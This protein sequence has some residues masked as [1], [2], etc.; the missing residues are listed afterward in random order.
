MEMEYSGL[1][2]RWDLVNRA[3]GG[4]FR[5]NEVTFLAGPSGSG[6]SF[7][8]NML[9]EDFA[10]ELNVK[11]PS[12]FKILAFSF[13]MSAE[14]EIIRSYSSQLKTSYSYLLSSYRKISREYYALIEETSRKVD[15]DVIHY[16]ESPGDRNQIANTVDD[17]HKK[18]PRHKL[19]ITIDHTLLMDYLDETSE[20]HL[21]ANMAKL[22]MYL[23]KKYRAMVIMLGQLNDKIENPD[24]IKNP[25]LHFPRKTD[26]HGSKQVFMASDTVAIIHRPELLHIDRYGMAEYNGNYG[27]PTKNLIAWHF[28]KSRLHGNE[29]IVLMKQDFEHGT[30][31]YP[32]E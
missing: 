32:Y 7:I 10:G 24:R 5:F 6:K 19:I 17:F 4:A 12:K 8:L 16:V 15:N 22:A 20:I 23:K 21:V 26:I 13:E 1:S 3:M 25:L 27:Y 31:I 14:D 11:F 9:R 29:G 28:L 2:C 30:L 18:F